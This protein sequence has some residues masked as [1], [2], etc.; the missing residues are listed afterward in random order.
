[1]FGSTSKSARCPE[2]T[3]YKRME[4]LTGMLGSQGGLHD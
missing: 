2:D 1:M 4:A 3:D